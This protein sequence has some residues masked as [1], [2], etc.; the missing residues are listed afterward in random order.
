MFGTWNMKIVSN[1]APTSDYM[2]VHSI[3]H[4][5][6]QR[7]QIFAGKNSGGARLGLSAY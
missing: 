3:N 4:E 6:I 2:Q 7:K 1:V 5:Y